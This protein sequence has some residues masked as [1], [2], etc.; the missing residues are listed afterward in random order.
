M[1][2]RVRA[3]ELPLWVLGLLLVIGCASEPKSARYTFSRPID[4]TGDMAPRG[5]TTRGPTPEAAPIPHRGWLALQEEGLSDF[6]RDRRAILA[7]VGPH[8]VSFDFLE[9]TSLTPELTE[10]DV[11]YQSWATEYVYL[12]ED[13]D[14]FISLQHVIVLFFETAD[15]VVGPHVTKHWRQD[16]TYEDRDL[17]VFRGRGRWE[18]V[19]PDP[20][21]ARGAWSQAVFQVDD[22]PRYE[23]LGRW[24]HDGN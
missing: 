14:D 8:R 24:H 22:S 13:R 3:T 15:G 17:H 23:A 9:T 2:V 1:D 6:E 21:R 16:W 20:D 7:M 4:L 10:L 12:L 11:P 5:G 18:R 19:R